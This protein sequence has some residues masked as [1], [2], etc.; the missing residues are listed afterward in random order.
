MKM[1]EIACLPFFE[2][3]RVRQVWES[4]RSQ[5]TSVSAAFLVW[6]WIF[7]AG[8]LRYLNVRLD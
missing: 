6:R 3:G 7:L 4:V 8:W 2:P 1:T 5:N